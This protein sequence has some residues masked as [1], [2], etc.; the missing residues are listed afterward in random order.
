M[1]AVECTRLKRAVQSKQISKRYERTSEWR[2]EWP[3]TLRVDLYSPFCPLCACIL[4][5][6]LFFNLLL[7]SFIYSSPVFTSLLTR[8]HELTS[9]AERNTMRILSHLYSIPDF[10]SFFLF[11]CPSLFF[12]PPFHQSSTSFFFL[13]FF[14]SSLPLPLPP[15]P[16]FALFSY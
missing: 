3:S 14:F 5:R 11:A 9:F 6:L 12:F 1:S 2:S 8:A 15:P 13:S 10:F 7:L 16:F 4:S